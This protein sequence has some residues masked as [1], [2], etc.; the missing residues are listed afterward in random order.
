MCQIRSP[1]INLCHSPQ[2]YSGPQI[3]QMRRV[4]SVIQDE[5][6]AFGAEGRTQIEIPVPICIFTANSRPPPRTVRAGNNI[7]PFGSNISTVARAVTHFGFVFWSRCSSEITPGFP[8]LSAWTWTVATDVLQPDES[9]SMRKRQIGEFRLDHRF[10][11]MLMIYL[12]GATVAIRYPTVRRQDEIGPGGLE[13]QIITSPS[14]MKIIII[15]SRGFDSLARGLL[16]GDISKL[17]EMHVM[18]SGLKVLVS[19]VGTQELET[20]RRSM[21]GHGYSTFA[22]LGK[23]CADYA[24][25]V[26]HAPHTV[27]SSFFNCLNPARAALKA[28]RGLLASISAAEK[29]S[30]S[31]TSHYLRLLLDKD[32]VPPELNAAIVDATC[33]CDPTSRV[34]RSIARSQKRTNGVGAGRHDDPARVASNDRTLGTVLTER[35]AKVVRKVYLLY[36]LLT[37]ESSL[38]DLFSFRL[39]RASPIGNPAPS[40]DPTRALRLAISGL[41]GKLVPEAIGLP[42]AFGFTDWELDR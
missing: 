17:A 16:S 7:S 28:F 2:Y 9:W 31:P 41:C 22:G 3:I 40:Q 36:L 26:T 18:T 42:D 39:F 13:R 4:K 6:R 27:K 37:V 33:D 10:Y 30:L 24:P 8:A 11:F 15:Q 34:A 38:V 32:L 23:L 5:A 21:G 19:M 35:E 20:A 25:A 29:S 12:P 1:P 14:V